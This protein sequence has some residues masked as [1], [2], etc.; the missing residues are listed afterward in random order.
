MIDIELNLENKE[1][2]K[3]IERNKKNINK[4][5]ILEE[6]GKITEKI[7]G[8]NINI[9]TC[10]SDKEDFVQ[11]LLLY[12]E[13][14]FK[15]LLNSKNIDENKI[16]VS[17]TI[18]TNEEIKRINKTYRNIDKITDVLSFPAIEKEDI[19]QFIKENTKEKNEIKKE[20]EIKLEK[21]EFFGDIVISLEKVVMQSEEYGHS[22]IREISYLLIH[23]FMHLLGYDHI[24]KEDEIIMRK[25]E[26]KVLNAL[27]IKR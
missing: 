7:E 1:I 26:E 16:Y 13:N 5:D 27:D 21:E 14:L 17:I 2:Y 3:I 23:S 8:S 19:D 4:K 20:K 12:I 6:I 22:L 15:F 10:L 24:E 9:A 18:V 25:E 11:S